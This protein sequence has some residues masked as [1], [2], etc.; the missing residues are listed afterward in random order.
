MGDP[1]SVPQLIGRRAED[2]EELLVSHG[3]VPKREPA[4]ASDQALVVDQSI[5]PGSGQIGD[6]I[7]IY[8]ED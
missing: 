3:L 8:L 7:I 2:A 4:D 6:Q 5:N 1:T